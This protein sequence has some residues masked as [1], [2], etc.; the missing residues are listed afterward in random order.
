M[1]VLSPVDWTGNLINIEKLVLGGI[2]TRNLSIFSSTC[3]SLNHQDN[4]T[5]KGRE[6]QKSMTP[7]E[8]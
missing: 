2:W 5:A 4:P 3:W 1:Q 6:F 8:K 7:E